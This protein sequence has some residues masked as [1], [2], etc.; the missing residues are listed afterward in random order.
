MSEMTVDTPIRYVISG[1][2]NSGLK[3]R[4]TEGKRK[5]GWG[6]LFA[7]WQHSHYIAWARGSSHLQERAREIQGQKD[8]E[9]F[10]CFKDEIEMESCELR[11]KENQASLNILET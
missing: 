8:G 3:T 11:R 6:G 9:S 1:Q 7:A 5:G 2:L 10:K 4:G